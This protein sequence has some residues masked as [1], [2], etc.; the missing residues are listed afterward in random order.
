M[1]AFPPGRVQSVAL[2][3]VVDREKEIEAF[4]PVEYWNIQAFFKGRKIEF[5]FRCFSIL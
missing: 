5:L 1:G 3:L 2:K 4:I